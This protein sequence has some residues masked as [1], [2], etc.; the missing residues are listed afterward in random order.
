MSQKVITGLE[1]I[2]KEAGAADA[3][4]LE[5][6]IK[7]TRE[8]LKQEK[9]SALLSQLDQELDVWQKKITVIVGEPAGRQG[10][11]KHA[12]YWVETLKNKG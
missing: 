2:A 3:V 8:A 5:A 4:K 7:G 6:A 12:H 9:G 10:V 1:N 11:A